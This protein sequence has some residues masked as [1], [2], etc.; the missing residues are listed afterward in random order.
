MTPIQFRPSTQPT[1]RRPLGFT[2]TE[3]LVV[4]AIIVLL[5][6]LLLAALGG[7]RKQGE[8]TTTLATMQAF[9]NACDAFQQEHNFYPGVVP[10]RILANDPQISGTENILLHLMGGFVRE[11]DVDPATY[12]AYGGFELSFSNP[13][14]GNYN[15]KIDT[16]RMGEGPVIG[17]KPYPP[18]LAPDDDEFRATSGQIICDDGTLDERGIPDLLDAW[19]QPII[20]IRRAKTTG[21]LVALPGERGQFEISPMCAYVLS[22]GLGDNGANQQSSIL[23]GSNAATNLEV[24]IGHPSLVGQSRGAIVVMSA[25]VDGVFFA[26]TDGPGSPE[27]PIDDIADTEFGAQ[28]VDEYDDVLLFAG[29]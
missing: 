9:V 23:A 15:I 27:Q 5:V 2:L 16:S 3:L 29:N 19:G 11:E 4:V 28:V 12:N 18:Y 14:G 10:E 20:A 13:S 22:D 6:G 8:R 7:A 17:G 21:R 24:I 26:S 25:G 1:R